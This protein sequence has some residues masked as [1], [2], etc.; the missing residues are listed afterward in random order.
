MKIKNVGNNLHYP[1]WRTCR[2]WLFLI[3][4][5]RLQFWFRKRFIMQHVECLRKSCFRLVVCTN[6]TYIKCLTKCI[7]YR[8]TKPPVFHNI[9]SYVKPFP[10][11]CMSF[12][13]AI[14]ICDYAFRIVIRPSQRLPFHHMENA[15]T[16]EPVSIGIVCICVARFVLSTSVL[17]FS[18][19]TTDAKVVRWGASNMGH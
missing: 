19:N 14:W 18:S 4:W 3:A 12:I 8:Q 17:S 13:I 2:F 16:A 1:V 7:F 6:K 10:F 15:I 5:F 11:I 9:F